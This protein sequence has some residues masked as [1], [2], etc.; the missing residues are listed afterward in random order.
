MTDSAIGVIMLNTD[1]PRLLGDIGNPATFNCP[2][3]YETVAAAT[4][5]NVIDV[6]HLSAQVLRQTISA[7]KKLAR[8]E[9]TV[10]GTSCGFLAVAQ[11]Q[12]Q[13]SVGVPVLTSSL[14]LIPTLR[15][16]FGDQAKI[17]VLTY[18]DRKLESSHFCGT[19]DE[20]IVIEGIPRNGHLY[21]CIKNDL[22]AIDE[23]VA[24]AEVV[25][26]A[27]S[28]L[29]RQPDIDAFLLECTNLSPFKRQLQTLFGRPV[30]D[31]VGALSWVAAASVPHLVTISAGS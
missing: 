15:S 30:F 24:S 17:A 4:V 3:R 9:V 27:K 22:P 21:Q 16:M 5:S 14:L 23:N 11:D 12:L 13:M 20:H 29:S 28:A 26:C 6:G 1:F 2:V 19:L 31:L 10:I 25:E 7:A 8:R 18:D